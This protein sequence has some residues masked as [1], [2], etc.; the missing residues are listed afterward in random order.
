MKFPS[1]KIIYVNG[2]PCI[3]KC[4][5]L[6]DKEGAENQLN[7]DVDQFNKFVSVFKFTS[8]FHGTKNNRWYSETDLTNMRD[9]HLV[10][11]AMCENF[12][13]KKAD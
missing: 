10:F 7:M 4:E 1:N 6:F 12:Q 3:I 9:R 2:V 5:R 8:R 13:I 11:E